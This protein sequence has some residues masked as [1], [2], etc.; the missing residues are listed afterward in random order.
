MQELLKFSLSDQFVQMISQILAFFGG[1]SLVLM[2][3][4]IKALI[5]PHRISW[6]LIWSF[7][8]QLIL[9]LF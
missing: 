8:E 1:M 2:V 5:A 4:A 3:V 7:E 9:N 6:H